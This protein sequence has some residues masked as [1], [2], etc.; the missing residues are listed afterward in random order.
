MI[1]TEL[2]ERLNDVRFVHIYSAGD[3]TRGLFEAE[4]SV[5]V[6]ATHARKDV[7]GPFLVFHY[8]STPEKPAFCAVINSVVARGLP[9]TLTITFNRTNILQT[10][11]NQV[12]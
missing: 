2:L 10:V 6:S 4:A 1:R 3:H 11:P 9:S 5:I 7:K 12:A 8:D